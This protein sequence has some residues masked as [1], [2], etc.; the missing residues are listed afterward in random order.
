M[1]ESF[2]PSPYTLSY[3]SQIGVSLQPVA[4]YTPPAPTADTA[5]ESKV[6]ADLTSAAPSVT[7]THTVPNT[8]ANTYL[9]VGV[10]MNIYQGAGSGTTTV[11]TTTPPS[12]NGKPLTFIGA[13]NEV[14]NAMRTELWGL[15]NPA[16]GTYGITITVTGITATVGIVAGATDFSGVNQSTPL[17]TGLTATAPTVCGSNYCYWDDDGTVTAAPAIKFTTATNALAVG[18]LATGNQTA[19]PT[20][21]GS[22]AQNQLWN[23]HSGTNVNN[24]IAG[25]GGSWAGAAPV[26]MSETLSAASYWSQ[27]G[28][29]LQPYPAPAPDLANSSNTTAEMVSAGA[30]ATLTVTHTVPT[31]LTNPYLLVGVTMNIEQDPAA[32]ISSV[33]I[34]TTNLSL[35]GAHNDSTNKIRVEMWG[36][37]NPPT[38]TGQT[39][40]VTANMDIV[41]KY[42]GVV[43]GAANFSGVNQGQP[44]SATVTSDDLNSPGTTSSLTI[45]DLTGALAV[46]VV[47]AQGSG[48][49]SINT[50]AKGGAETSL[51]TTDSGTTVGED[52]VGLSGTWSGSSVTAS[53]TFENGATATASYWSQ[54]GVSLI[55]TTPIAAVVN[56]TT[57]SVSFSQTVPSTCTNCYLVVG[58]SMNISADATA[59]V[60]GITYNGVAL[61]QI[62][63]TNDNP[64]TPT[65]RVEQWGLVGTPV[66]NEQHRN[67]FRQYHGQQR[68]SDRQRRVFQRRR[69]APTDDGAHLRKY[70]RQ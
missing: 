56:S 7:L 2:G 52:V 41:G 13:H 1:S 49:Q 17:A 54:I 9:L 30:T 16:P 3:W 70:L 22:T 25:F 14:Y 8:T 44:L 11:S 33:V 5:N 35:I 39:I 12:W 63:A 23:T 43:A 40:T 50:I 26:N 57:A 67:K 64:T 48:A 61:T 34:G 4:G 15:A 69:S 31:T 27:I 68:G 6:T 32:T 62:G 21:T 10:S 37:L 65:Y 18:V 38:G 45:T 24:D 53:E 29:A 55:P 28:V 47:G 51:W 20:I 58:V 60:S 46:D 66:W 19:I 36:L 42:I 59:S